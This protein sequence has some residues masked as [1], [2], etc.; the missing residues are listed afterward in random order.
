[1]TL[2]DWIVVVCVAP[3]A[4]HLAHWAINVAGSALDAFALKALHGKQRPETLP[5][6]TIGVDCHICEAQKYD[7]CPHLSDDVEE[8][9]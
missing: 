7:P 5:R 8:A 2:K 1:M 6:P 9:S 3:F 4:W